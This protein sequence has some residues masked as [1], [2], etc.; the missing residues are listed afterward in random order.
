MGSRA[1]WLRLA[2]GAGMGL[3]AFLALQII[4]LL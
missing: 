2:L 4:K 1:W 3:G